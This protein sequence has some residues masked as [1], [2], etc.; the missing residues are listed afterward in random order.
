MLV[1]CQEFDLVPTGENGVLEHHDIGSQTPN[2]C[3]A[4]QTDAPSRDR[5]R[6]DDVAIGQRRVTHTDLLLLLRA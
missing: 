2:R 6:Q 1:S 4:L 3:I 5:H